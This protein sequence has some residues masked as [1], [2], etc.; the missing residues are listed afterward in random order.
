MV[1]LLG[2]SEQLEPTGPEQVKLTEAL[3]PFT[4]ATGK[5]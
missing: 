5:E 2:E 1:K 4:G 3:E